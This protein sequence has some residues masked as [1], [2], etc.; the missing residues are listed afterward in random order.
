[1]AVPKVTPGGPGAIKGTGPL[2]LQNH[3]N[4]V[5]FR[6]IWVVPKKS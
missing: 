5:R 4:P 6:N 2:Y 3:G 1:V